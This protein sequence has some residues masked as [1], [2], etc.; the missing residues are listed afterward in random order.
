[1]RHD[2][3]VGRVAYAEKNILFGYAGQIATAFMSFWLRRVFVLHLSETLLGINS[4]YTNVLSLLSMADLGIG[5][6]LSFS[7][8][9][10]VA[11]GNTEKVKAYIEMYR[12]TYRVIAVVIAALGLCF[13]PFLQYLIKGPEGVSVRDLTVYYLIFL[14]NTVTSY[15][16]SYKYS[17]V[18]AEQK[19]YIQTNIITITKIITVVFQILVLIFIGNF[20]AYLLTDSCIQLIQKIFVS[21][22]LDRKYPLLTDRQVTSLSKEE[23]GVIW[24]KTRALLLHRIGDVLR[25]QTDALVISSMIQVAAAGFVD[26][27]NLV[28]SAASNFVHILFNSVISGFGNLIATESRAR[29][30]EVYQAYRF[31]AAWAYGFSATG[32]YTLLTP[33][34]RLWLG[35]YWT[36]STTVVTLII[37]DYYFRGDRIVNSNFKTA[38]GAF[39][40]DKYLTLV[41]GVVNLVLSVYLASKF[42]LAGVFAGTVISGL[43]GNVTKPYVVYRVC[44]NESLGP[45]YVDSGKYLLATLVAAALCKGAEHIF[46][47]EV[48]IPGFILMMVIVT[49]IFNAVFILAFRKRKE[50]RYLQSV[51]TDRLK[52]LR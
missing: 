16:V 28:I 51:F 46:L 43:I 29:Q 6:A 9:A 42:G 52:K 48:T 20:L 45:Y 24:M 12:K 27:Y 23:R 38:A 41:Q 47:R 37:A 44:F 10:P 35:D 26:N 17:L 30:K 39:E 5:T 34:I 33:L 50:F 40:Q 31:F 11:E 7:L 25:L 14:F 8:Y 19:N 32:F 36:I 1:M 13:V 3:E 2:Q 15:L 18:N 49:I 21:K 4:T 22:Y